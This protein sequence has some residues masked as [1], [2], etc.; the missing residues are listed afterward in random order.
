VTPVGGE[1][2]CIVILS[3]TPEYASFDK[4][5]CEFPDLKEELSCAELN[6]PEKGAV[7]CMRTLRNFLRGKSN[8]EL[9]LE[10]QDSL[11]AV[12]LR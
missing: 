12:Q 4:A 7:T 10:L 11:F 9:H 3:V 8:R 2:V 6:S 5:R 1:Q